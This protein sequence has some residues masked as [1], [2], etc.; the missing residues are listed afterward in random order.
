MIIIMRGLPG[1]GKSTLARQFAQIIPNTMI[2]SA[3]HY[4]EGPNNEY[5]FDKA[6]LADAHQHCKDLVTKW[7]PLGM[8]IVVDNTNTRKWEYAFY[9]ELAKAHNIATAIAV[10]TTEWAWNPVECH[11]R[12]THG[13]PLEA[14]H[15]MF[16]RWEW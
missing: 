7:L 2:V 13:V 3:D 5:K 14:I 8:D 15:K 16:Q 9:L 1:S 10:P 11:K 4:F 6:K 12:C